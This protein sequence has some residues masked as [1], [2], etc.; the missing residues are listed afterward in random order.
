MT[1]P[2]AVIFDLDGTLADSA[3]DI[4]AALNVALA[5]AGHA[6]LDLGTVKTMVGAGARRL[7]ERALATNGDAGRRVSTAA[8]HA[9]FLD[10][11]HA[12]SAH[13]TTLYPGARE[14]LAD[15]AAQGVRLGVCTN[16]PHDLTLAILEALNVRVLFG[17]VAGSVPGAALKPA[18]DLLRKVLAELDV[19]PG[20]AV[21]VGDSR[22]DA[23]AACAAGTRCILISHGYSAESVEQIGADAVVAGF[24]DMG[25]AIAA[26]GRGSSDRT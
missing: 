9:A 11:Y 25:P 16:K 22:A 6:P 4:A 17:S 8:V 21:M 7:V 19:E 24:L 1:L 12:R 15:L 20:S 10:A 26:L 18:P 3:P 5:D 13:L 23:G 2:R 14:V